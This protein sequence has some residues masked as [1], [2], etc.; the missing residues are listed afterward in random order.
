[1]WDVVGSRARGDAPSRAIDDSGPHWHSSRPELSTDNQPV[2]EAGFQLDWIV[3]KAPDKD[4]RRRYETARGLARDIERHLAGDPVEAG[5]LSGSYR[6]RKFARKHR[7]A[8]VAIA[9]PWPY[10]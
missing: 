6:L 7:A 1:V 3:M 2:D 9:A 10:S 8:L 5:P 4:G